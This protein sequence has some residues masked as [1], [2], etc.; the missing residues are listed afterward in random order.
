MKGQSSVMDGL[1]FMLVCSSAATLLFYTASLYGAN[2]NTQISSVYNYEYAGTALVTMHY[3]QDN[4]NNWFWSELSRKLHDTDPQSSVVN[5][6]KNNAPSVWNNISLAAPSSN[7][8]LEFDGAPK[9]YCSGR[10][11]S[12]FSCSLAEPQSNTIF[13]SSSRM[14]GD[15]VVVLRLQ[16]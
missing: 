6:V 15:W 3:A 11:A 16:Y 4:D 1:I 10:D 14:D 9:F 12:A 5:Y 13:S 8:V 7:V 2:T